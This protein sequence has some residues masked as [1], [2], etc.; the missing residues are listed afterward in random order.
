[1]SRCL[2]ITPESKGEPEE[3][4]SFTKGSKAQG[5]L[6]KSM[7]RGSCVSLRNLLIACTASYLITGKG[8]L[9]N[10][11]TNLQRILLNKVVDEPELLR[12]VGV[13]THLTQ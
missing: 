10:M 9:P 3:Y 5:N 2:I 1:M 11:A 12:G 8:L 13:V 7:I 6:W 4:G